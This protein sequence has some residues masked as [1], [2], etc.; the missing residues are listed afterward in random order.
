MLLKIKDFLYNIDNDNYHRYTSWEN[1]YNAFSNGNDRELL[2][3]NLAFYLASWGMY[4]GS[5][6]LLQ[7][8]H[9]I[10]CDAVDII[11]KYKNLRCGVGHEI[12]L[13]KSDELG[14]LILDLKHYYSSISFI[15]DNITKNISPSDTLISK[16]ILGTLGCLP[17][18]DRYFIAGVNNL[19]L[20]FSRMTHNQLRNLL[21]FLEQEPISKQIESC[22]LLISEQR[23]MYYP[24]MKIVDMYFWQTGFDL[25]KM[26]E[27]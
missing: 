15:K 26:T 22:Q 6:G 7:K 16:V 4:R 9:K 18:C 13:Q 10:H 24:I 5:S 14:S 17:A 11:L 3:L 27:Q 12:S 8:S 1:C 20:N 25:E 21:C 19:D 2:A 23:K